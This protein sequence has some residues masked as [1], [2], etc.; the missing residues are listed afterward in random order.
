MSKS[1]FGQQEI[2]P[3][4]WKKYEGEEIIFRTIIRDG[5]KYLKK[6]FTKTG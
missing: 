3:I 2:K 4:V 5:K 6:S 1:I